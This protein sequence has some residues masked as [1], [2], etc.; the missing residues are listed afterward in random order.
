MPNARLLWIE[1]RYGP[2]FRH[3]RGLAQAVQQCARGVAA[4][5]SAR[6]RSVFSRM[7]SACASYCGTVRVPARSCLGRSGIV[8]SSFG[9]SAA[10]LDKK[11]LLSGCFPQRLIDTVLP[12]GTAFLEMLEN[13]P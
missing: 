6:R 13:V 3:C 7:A 5:R 4:G 8:V 2:P 11:T 10:E 1:R 12:A 9:E